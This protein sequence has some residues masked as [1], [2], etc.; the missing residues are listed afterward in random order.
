M[1]T[2][3]QWCACLLVAIIQ[4]SNCCNSS[5]VQ[6]YLHSRRHSSE[7]MFFL[8]CFLILLVSYNL[9]PHYSPSLLGKVGE[10]RIHC[11][12]MDISNSHSEPSCWMKVLQR[13]WR[14]GVGVERVWE[15]RKLG[16]IDL[17]LNTRSRNSNR[18]KL[19]KAS[20]L[21]EN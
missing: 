8:S 1:C 2:H 17:F 19:L 6:E 18:T 9:G 21:P 3:V 14:E 20:G 11:S 7:G 12:L 5:M 13:S 16:L 10:R 15:R 4:A